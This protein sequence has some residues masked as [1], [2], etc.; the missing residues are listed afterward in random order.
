METRSGNMCLSHMSPEAQSPL[1][2]FLFYLPG[3][4]QNVQSL[5]QIPRQFTGSGE[6]TVSPNLH[7]QI[8]TNSLK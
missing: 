4:H 1:P 7:P 8:R 6:Q 5:K 3:S 2:R